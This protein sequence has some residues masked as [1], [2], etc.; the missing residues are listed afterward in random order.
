M[1]EPIQDKQ[2]EFLLLTLLGD[3]AA[4]DFC[5]RIF[6]I[7]QIWDDV[8]DG[9]SITELELHRAF[10]QALIVL[11]AHPFYQRHLAALAAL[12][13]TTMLDYVAAVE[14]ERDPGEHSRSIAY[15]LRESPTTVVVYC[16]RLV[17]GIDYAMKIAA[18]VRR[19][20]H[21]ETLSEYLAG[22]PA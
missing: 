19:Y 16:A 7:T 8:I 13:E 20:F 12:L 11:P 21:D 10:W 22:L 5:E 9:D 6:E 15:V 3:E 4:V 2:H 17:G 14:L 1:P 18:E